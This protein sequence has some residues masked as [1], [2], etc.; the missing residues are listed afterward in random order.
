MRDYIR[1]VGNPRRVKVGSFVAGADYR[2]DESVMSYGT[3]ADC[4]NLRFDN[5][6]LRHSYGINADIIERASAVW[7]FT[8][9]DNERREYVN[10]TM[11]TADD[12]SVFYLGEDGTVNRLGDIRFTST[13]MAV[14]YRLYDEDVI[15]ICSPTDHMVVWNGIDEAYTV[16]ESP[17]IS[18][19]AM[20]Y[21]RL[22]VTTEG[23]K[24][25][26]WFSDDLDP[27]N[28]NKELDEGGFIQLIDD[29]GRSNKVISFLNYI[30]IFR[31][32]GISR[33]TAYGDQTEFYVSNL[34][35]SSGKIYADT[36]TLCGDRIY[37]LASDGLYVFDGLTTQKI[38]SNLDDAIVGGEPCG[39]YYEG[40]Y[41][42]ALR[43][44]DEND[45][46]K[47][48]NGMIV[49]S[50]TGYTIVKG[51]GIQRLCPTKD[52]LYAALDDGR[53][54]VIDESGTFFGEPL[55]KKWEMPK[56]DFGYS[57]LKILKE[58]RVSS[59]ADAALSVVSDFG[60]KEFKLTEG[61]NALFVN[62]MG[63]AFKITLESDAA[64]ICLNRFELTFK[65]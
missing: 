5:G 28:W 33:L 51:V 15:I 38:L 53:V 52:K 32:N 45:D 40:N 14:N 13:P 57:D 54:G 56:N 37:F 34:F 21:E 2:L 24:N 65:R 3:A 29:R 35:V 50:P 20:H 64:E 59:D 36:V 22:F 43:L 30:Y 41:Y 42:L 27:T 19:M 10:I 63:H 8:R 55:H 12:G 4:A 31:D 1:I 16:E 49:I 39:A 25:A 18:S 9:F 47:K 7:E 62:M 46:G 48:N 58:I 26:V 60:K 44:K 61:R 23:E 17:Y 11:F 6:A